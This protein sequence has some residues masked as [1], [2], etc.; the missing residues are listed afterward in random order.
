LLVLGAKRELATYAHTP[1]VLIDAAN[2]ANALTFLAHPDEVSCPVN[3]E[4]DI[5]W[6]D[7]EVRGFTGIE[8]WNGLSEFKNVIKSK[9]HAIF[10]AYQPH[11]IARGPQ[12]ATLE[13]WN[14]LHAE[15]LRVVAIGGSDAHNLPASLGPLHRR[16]FPYAWHFRGVNTHLLLPRAL[17]WVDA[18]EDGKLIL[19]ALR[20]GN[21]FVGY[22]LPHSTR[23]FRFSAVGREKTAIMGDQMDG[24]GGVTFQIRMPFKHPCRLL[25]DGQVLRSFSG[26]ESYTHITTEPGV[27]RVEADIAYYGRMRSWIFSNPIYV[28]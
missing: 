19:G 24:E 6:V 13:R 27:Y 8:L 14:R 3:H 15:G 18:H 28:R 21:A 10:Y 16:I 1:Q 25:K 12:A 22:D 7:W 4:T 20:Q 23:G 9:L 26:R 17:S 5:T 2:K 11:L